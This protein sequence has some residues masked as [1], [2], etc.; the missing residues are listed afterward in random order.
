MRKK[1]T[2]SDVYSFK[3]FKPK[4]TLRGIFGDPHARIITLMR[5]GKKLYAVPAVP[6]I[7]PGMTARSTGFGTCP[8]AIPA[9]TWKWSYDA[10]SA[11]S[12]AR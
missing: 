10:S 8:A 5:Q 6:S 9:S 4:K 1:R 2:L 11:R 12:A 7:G 3:Y